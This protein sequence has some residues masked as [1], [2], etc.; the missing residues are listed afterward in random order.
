MTIDLSKYPLPEGSLR[1]IGQNYKGLSP[2]KLPVGSKNIESLVNNIDGYNAYRFGRFRTNNAIVLHDDSK[3]YYLYVRPQYTG[4][5]NFFRKVSG[6]IDMKLDVDHVL[7]RNL[8]NKLGYNY[9]LLSVISSGV[10]RRHGVYE[11]DYYSGQ[12]PDLCYS[13]ERIYHKI[14]S[15]NPLA[16]LKKEE[17]ANGF[18]ATSSPKHGLTLKQNGI[19]SSAFLLHEIDKNNI[20]SEL[21]I[22]D[23]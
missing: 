18:S 16:R 20:K 12:V 22:I 15:R 8:A 6:Q 3:S 23:I 4:Y 9:V 19:W 1:W 13:D 17:I 14:L 11:K 2:Q 21:K 10:N 5:R 7:S